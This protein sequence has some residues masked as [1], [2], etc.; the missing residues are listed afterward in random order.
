[1]RG[2]KKEADDDYEAPAGWYDDP[3]GLP[4][5]RW[6]DGQ[7][8]TDQLAPQPAGQPHMIVTK[9]PSH[10]S[11]TFHLLMT[12]FTLGLWLPVWALYGFIKSLTREKHVS[13][14]YY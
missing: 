8:W 4:T 2:K 1:M 12:I 14:V 6:W 3:D 11:P 5:L 7:Q 13:K 9:V 10:T